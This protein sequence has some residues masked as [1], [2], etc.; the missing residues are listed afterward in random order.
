MSMDDIGFDADQRMEIDAGRASGVDVSVYAKKQFLAIQMHVIRLGLEA[1]LD[2][3]VYAR[4]EYDWFQM[5]EIRK[6]MLAGVDYTVYANPAIPFDMMRQ[7]RKGLQE[8]INLY[9]YREF[10]PHILRQ[11]R[12]ALVD[13][14]SIV[15]YV[16]EGYEED[17]LEEIRD[18]LKKQLP[19]EEYLSRDLRG[20]SIREIALG[21]Q[22]GIDP[23]IYATAEYDWK[24]M[25]ELRLGLEHQVDVSRYK[26][27]LYSWAQMR[28]LRLGL[29]EGLDISS[30]SSFIYVPSDMEKKRAQLSAGALVENLVAEIEQADT[31]KADDRVRVFV[32]N[33]EMEARIEIAARLDETITTEQILSALH[34]Y[35]VRHGIDQ[36]AIERIVT[37]RAY[38]RTLIVAQGKKPSKGVDGRY[39]FFFQTKKDWAPTILADG[40]AD[41]SSVRFFAQVK[42]GD[43]IAVYHPAAFGAAGFSV[44]G[45][46]L[47]STKGREKSVLSGKGFHATTDG[48]TYVADI[49]GKI[50]LIDDS[51][52]EITK[53]CVLEDVTAAMGSVDFDGSVLINGDVGSGAFIHATEDV[54]VNGVVEA[55]T[56]C[57]GGN[58]LLRGGITGGGTGSIEAGKNVEGSFMEYATIRA[59]GNIEAN[60]CLNCELHADEWIHV[61]GKKGMLTG[62]MAFAKYGIKA[63]NVGNRSKLPTILRIGVSDE[64]L[65][66]RYERQIKIS[67]CEKQL[68]IL[69]NA[70][71]DF[72]Q[73]YSPEVY[74]AM[75]LYQKLE[76]AVY[77]KELDYEKLSEELTL[78]E[79]EIEQTKGAKAVIGGIL[80]EG[81]TVFIDHVKTSVHDIRDV[82][83]RRVK[84]AIVMEPNE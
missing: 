82:T 33:D 47:A 22:N 52:I 25:R 48:K 53:M 61:H 72:R 19:I 11:L 73:K 17:Q 1:S 29:E 67:E 54:V 60:Y 81:T 36:E 57:C 10:D 55:A 14:V 74:T 28:E 7:L 41:Y 23:R 26:N 44:S 8:G 40:T 51:R 35:G 70:A 42:A 69:K 50:E 63:Y 38:N 71:L 58:V 83:L 65:H 45:K 64:L 76:K 21:L 62:G 37:E 3:S 15:T 56:I 4:E 5:D 49:T 77:T 12:K 30:Y 31:A 16:K 6:G 24:Q 78:I 43:K 2:V 18:A 13:H 84:D 32:S 20:I 80:Y 59:G 68:D 46:L 79:N 75:E 34:A 9:P 27:S 39:E 66:A